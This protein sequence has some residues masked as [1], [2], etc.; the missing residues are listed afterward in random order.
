LIEIRGGLTIEWSRRASR[1]VPSRHR[2]AR[3]IR[4]VRR[5]RNSS[6][7]DRNPPLPSDSALVAVPNVFAGILAGTVEASFVYRDD[8]VAVFMD[9]QPLNPG[10]AL[11]IPLNPARFLCELD[12]ETAA[13][14]FGK[15]KK[16][17]SKRG[18]SPLLAL[19]IPSDRLIHTS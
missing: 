11:V 10:H 14:M 1:L 15:K 12:D 8:K 13:H 17:G 9:S 16:R 2:G 19:G 4:S 5:P 6:M 3:L 18:S 7:V